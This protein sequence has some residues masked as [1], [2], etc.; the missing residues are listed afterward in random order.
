MSRLPLHLINMVPITQQQLHDG[1]SS[2]HEIR[3][4]NQAN[5]NPNPNRT[6]F[7]VTTRCTRDL[8]SQPRAHEIRTHNHVHTRFAVATPCTRDS[9]SQP[10]AHEIRS[11][12]HVHSI[13]WSNPGSWFRC[14]AVSYANS[15]ADH[16]LVTAHNRFRYPSPE[17]RVRRRVAE[18]IGPHRHCL[19]LYTSGTRINVVEVS[20]LV[21]RGGGMSTIL[22]LT[23]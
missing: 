16:Y 9:Q 6:R 8:Q 13:W 18:G 19:Q 3:S 21:H 5:P 12:N 10:R 11:R 7:A 1:S 22:G 20:P 23:S 17:V 4:H 2:A 14:R 15:S